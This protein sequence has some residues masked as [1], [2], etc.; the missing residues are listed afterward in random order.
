MM[1]LAAPANAVSIA[2]QAAGPHDVTAQSY[3][4][5]WFPPGAIFAIHNASGKCLEIEN[6]SANSGAQAQQWDCVGQRGMYFQIWENP[7]GSGNFKLT[8]LYTRKCLEIEG[9]SYSNGA[10]AQQWDCVGQLGAVWHFPSS[11]NSTWI[12]NNSGK[13]LEIENSSYN[14]G[15]RAQQW[16]CVGQHG[17]VWSLRYCDPY[18]N[19]DTCTSPNAL[20]APASDPLIGKLQAT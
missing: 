9:S 16:D 18:A 5:W 3:P 1:M 15:A 13:C 7:P 19:N 17:S 2:N 4:Q 11:F 20:L 8:S 14:N 12:V 10:R 6:S